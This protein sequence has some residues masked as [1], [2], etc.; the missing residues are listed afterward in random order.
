[1][2]FFSS[3]TVGFSA[4]PA[5]PVATQV[6]LFKMT[7]TGNVTGSTLTFGGSIVSPAFIIFEL[8]QDATG[9]RTFVWPTNVLAAPVLNSGANET[10]SVILYYDGTNAIAVGPGVVNP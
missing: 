2:S 7:L 6:Q 5:F 4:T 8:T 1:M 10:T 3:T 9:G